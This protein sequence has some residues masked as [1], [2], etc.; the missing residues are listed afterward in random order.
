MKESLST[1]FE[2]K[3][4]FS[5]FNSYYHQFKEATSIVLRRLL[6]GFSAVFMGVSCG[7]AAIVNY[8]KYV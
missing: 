5:F 6:Q 3:R 2:M 8:I 1:E 7:V 4:S